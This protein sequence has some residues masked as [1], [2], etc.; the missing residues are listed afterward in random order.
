MT[1]ENGFAP[2]I[3]IPAEFVLLKLNPLTTNGLSTRSLVS[4]AATALLPWNSITVVAA[5]VAMFDESQLVAVDHEPV[6]AE[7]QVCV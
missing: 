2:A 1:N 3:V 6:V 5:L 4:V 7:V